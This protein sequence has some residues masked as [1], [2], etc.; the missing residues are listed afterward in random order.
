MALKPWYNVITPR[1]DLVEGK[2]LDA[3]EFAVHLDH[4]RLGT[5]PKDYTDPERF[6]HRTYL[7]QTLLDMSAQTI[8]RFSGITTETSP[9]F[10]LT[11]QFGGGKTH[12]LTLL[13]H[14]ATTGNKAKKFQG[15]DRILTKAE[16]DE[17]KTA[18]VAIFVGTEFSSVTGR[19]D[20]DEPN[21]KTP[22]GELAFQIGGAK[23]FEQ[24]AELD[25]EFIPPGGD[26][27]NK[28]FD[29]KQPYLLLFDELLNYVSKHRNYHDL[30]AQFYNFLQTLTEFVRSRDNIVL[31]VSIPASEMEMNTEDQADYDRFKKMLDRLGKAMFMSAE[32]ETTEIIRRR[33]FEW[34]GLP[35]EAR[36]TI[37]E[38]VAWLDEHKTHL[39]FNT[40]TA[41]QQFESSYPFHPAVLS[42]FERKWQA[43]PRFQQT[44]GVLRL[45]ALWVAKAYNDGFK[46]LTKD[47]LIT[48]GTAPLED[49]N[50]RAAVFEQ[51]GENR[52]EAAVTTDIAGKDESW[53]GRLDLEAIDAIK[54]SRLHKKCATTIFF[55]SNG[56]QT[57]QGLATL[58]EIKLSVG[59]PDLDIGLVDGV[60]QSLLDSCYYL[61]AV[62]NK[63]KYSI[64]ENLIKRF[65]D[66]RAS[67]QPPTINELVEAEIRKVFDKGHGF[68]KVMFPERNNQVTD[69]PV[70]S[71]VV[72]HPSKRN[73]DAETKTFLE[74]IINNYGS[75][76][77]VYKSGLIFCVAED[78]Q[79]IKEEAKKF[80]AWETIYDEALELKLDEEQRKQVKVSMD[81]AK[82]DLVENIWKAYKNVVLLNKN[83]QLQTK[84]LGLIHSSQARTISELYLSRL[85]SEGE[86]TNEINPM[87]LVRNWPPAFTAWSTKNVR[88]VFYQSPQFPRLI[89]PESI[90][91]TISK[92]V[93]NGYL[94]Y[95]G[96]Q[97]GKYEPFFFEKS[98]FAGDVEISDEMYIL[99]AEEARKNIE[100][101]KLATMKIV[102]P[103][104]TLEPKKTYSFIAKGYDQHS[105]EINIDAIEWKTSYGSITEAGVLTVEE[106]EGVYKVT[107]LSNGISATSTVTVQKKDESKPTPPD[108]PTPPPPAGK[109]KITWSGQVDTKKWNVFYT[110]VLAK[111]A[112]NPN[113]K[114]TVKFEVEDEA[115]NA[116]QKKEETKT[117]L[118]EMGLD[119]NI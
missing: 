42:L 84:D 93:E 103:S 96:K 97:G 4:V 36:K 71:L 79:P 45:L 19:G 110:K 117:A 2:P 116:E 16:I 12:S 70:L 11:T 104:V 49:P 99:T 59:D 57:A 35:D 43:L 69:R 48:L 75:S 115:A 67:I 89:N 88:D 5:A 111:F 39:S 80:L 40:E 78:G 53:A 7:T 44:R 51:L 9:V 107:A 119:E 91:A 82:K 10:N 21:R 47:A 113:L 58:P 24:F 95:T 66:R 1:E 18:K 8:R 3:S 38:Y 54:K 34:H 14:L 86:I 41:R 83:N 25:R 74:D 52:L 56:G 33:L 22:W 100:P 63:F 29:K 32:K 20:G 30:G 94:A 98:L 31:A 73:A 101:R 76:A 13:Y 85:E 27:L 28:L 90:K 92:G 55:E 46:K 61:T 87:F 23:G 62:N 118:R 81:R 65:S 68:E 109:T 17:I 60:I 114:I 15:V 102:P 72:M 112:S 77:R 26:D 6:F 105:E 64:H 108:T 37:G 106:T 50:F